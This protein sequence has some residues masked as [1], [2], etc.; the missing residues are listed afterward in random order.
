MDDVL[1]HLIAM[2]CDFFANFAIIKTDNIMKTP[3]SHNIDLKGYLRD[4]FD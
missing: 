1:R 3:Q 4:K 2:N